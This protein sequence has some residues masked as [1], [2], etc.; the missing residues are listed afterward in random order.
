MNNEFRYTNAA[1]TAKP[2]YLTRKWNRLYPGW[3]RRPKPLH[4]ASVRPI[5]KAA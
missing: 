1:E 5:R 4:P 2:G 3:N